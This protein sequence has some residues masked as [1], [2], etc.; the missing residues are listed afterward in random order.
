MWI[1]RL[2]KRLMLLIGIVGVLVIYVGFFY[3]LFQQQG[4]ATLPWY[5]LISPWLCIYFG[6]NPQQQVNTRLWL[7]QK[8]PFKRK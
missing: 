5:I 4:S 8:L 2:T 7:K 1:E 3:L 6:L